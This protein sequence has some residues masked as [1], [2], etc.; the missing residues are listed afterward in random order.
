MYPKTLNEGAW[1]Y[2]IIDIVAILTESARPR[3]YWSDLKV[4]LKQEGSEL[5]AKIGQL[6]FKSSDGKYYLT[7]CGNNI[8]NNPIN[9]FKESR[10]I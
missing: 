9:S 4:K 6:K 8:Q 7:D 1:F 10:A 5:S 3:K 2:S